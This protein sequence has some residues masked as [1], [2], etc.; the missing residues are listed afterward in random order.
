MAVASK[1]LVIISYMLK[2]REY[3]RYMNTGLHDRKMKEYELFL[4]KNRNVA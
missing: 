3:C 4:R 2:K 1:M